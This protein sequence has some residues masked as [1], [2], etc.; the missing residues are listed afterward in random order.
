FRIADQ[1]RLTL[2]H[3]SSDYV[4]DG[5]VSVHHED[6]LPSPLGVYGQT[7]AAG[8][9]LVRQLEEHYLVRTSWLVGEG[10][11][12]VRTMADLAR[13]GFCPTVVDDQVGR[14]SFAGDLAAGIVHLLGAGAQY[15]TYNLTNS[16]PVQS[17]A[18]IARVIFGLC[19]RSPIDV[20]PITTTEYVKQQGDKLIAARPRH[21]TLDLARITAAGYEPPPARDRLERWFAAHEPTGA[22]EPT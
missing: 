19:G 10:P 9:A 13:R 11:N 22:A 3:V 21:S 17:W 12:F 15:G 16:G 7:K 1:H 20:V 5:S 2:V 14:L 8:D 4:F 18:D 6:E